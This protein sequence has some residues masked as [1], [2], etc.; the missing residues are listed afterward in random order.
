MSGDEALHSAVMEHL[1]DRGGARRVGRQG[2]TRAAQELATLTVWQDRG[3]LAATVDWQSGRAVCLDPLAA[4]C[5]W[6]G[7]QG[8]AA[9]AAAHAA[10]LVL[11]LPVSAD[12]RDPFVLTLFGP[13]GRGRTPGLDGLLVSALGDLRY[14]IRAQRIDPR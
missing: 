9:T 11:V 2:G 8:Q 3:S 5:D 14:R 12:E 13:P 1:T 7:A 10:G 4:P 6:V